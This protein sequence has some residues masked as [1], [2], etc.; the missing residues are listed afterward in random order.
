VNVIEGSSLFGAICLTAMQAIAGL[1]AASRGITHNWSEKAV[2][3]LVQT[4]IL[5]HVAISASYDPARGRFATVGDLKPKLETLSL[6]DE[7]RVAIVSDD[8]TGVAG[9]SASGP[10]SYQVLALD[11]GRRLAVVRAADPMDALTKVCRLQ[12]RQLL[13]A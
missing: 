12:A 5:R 6:L 3:P 8:E 7:C 1:A 13:S 10:T 9:L 11:N 2:I 4:A